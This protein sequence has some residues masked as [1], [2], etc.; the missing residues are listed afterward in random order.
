MALHRGN[1]RR[2]RGR[3]RGGNVMQICRN[4]LCERDDIH[5]K[6][7]LKKDPRGRPEKTPVKNSAREKRAKEK[8]KEQIS[9]LEGKI[10]ELKQINAEQLCRLVNHELLMTRIRELE[11]TLEH[12]KKNTIRLAAENAQL[13]ES[14]SGSLMEK[15]GG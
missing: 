2:V 14:V 9:Q 12:T 6:H 1:T 10:K 8:L 5:E 7:N 11:T 4:D 15:N 3:R 13:R